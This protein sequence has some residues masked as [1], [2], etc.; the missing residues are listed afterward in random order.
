MSMPRSRRP[1]RGWSKPSTSGRSSRMPAWARRAPSPTSRPIAA[2]CGPAR[3][4]RTS[5]A[6]AWR[7]CST[8]RLRECAPSGCR[9]PAPMGATTRATRRSTPP[10]SRAPSASRYACK[11]CAPTAPP[12]IRKALP[13]CTGLARKG[14]PIYGSPEESYG[15]E[16]KRLAWETIAP[17][18]VDGCSPLRTSHLRD[19]VGPDIHFGSEQFIDEL[20]HAAG[21]DP[22]EF[23]V[24][25]LTNPRHQAV[26]KAAADKAG[27]SSL[28]KGRGIAFAD[29][30]GTA[31]AVVAEVEVDRSSGRIWAKRFTVAHDCGLII[32]PLTLRQTIEG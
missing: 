19:P 4:S 18:V 1:E 10:F 24:R 15:F 2:R 5:R 13:P 23:R 17:L 14:N 8:C 16:N 29:R 9:D 20:A 11:A 31:V 26:V 25:Y 32:N 30:N 6:T 3:R 7:S 28:G 22:V 27:W 21:V 12:G